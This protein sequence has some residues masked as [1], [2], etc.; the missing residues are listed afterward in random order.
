[1][2]G[3]LL[4]KKGEGGLALLEDNSFYRLDQIHG[5]KWHTRFLTN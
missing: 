4:V 5:R 1:M 3:W 2:T